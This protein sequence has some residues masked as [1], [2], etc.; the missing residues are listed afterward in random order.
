MG[1]SSES[2][3]FRLGAPDRRRILWVA[4]LSTHGNSLPGSRISLTASNFPNAENLVR[5]AS[6]QIPD[7]RNHTS[8]IILIIGAFK[9]KARL[10]LPIRLRLWQDH[11]S[12]YNN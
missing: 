9:L 6:V 8:I 2:G 10:D 3:Y 12:Q 5:T 7:N 1:E 11:P 4:C